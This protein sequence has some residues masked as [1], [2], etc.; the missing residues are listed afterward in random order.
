MDAIDGEMPAHYQM[1][2]PFDSQHKDAYASGYESCEQFKMP[3]NIYK[4]QTP[5]R[6]KPLAA[7]DNEDHQ[8]LIIPKDF[9]N[10]KF[11]PNSYN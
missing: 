1:V 5:P 7:S 9:S 8:E 10:Q 3:L 2:R 4:P 11:P 6:G